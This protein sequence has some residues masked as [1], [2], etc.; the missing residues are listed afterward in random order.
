MTDHSHPDHSHPDRAETVREFRNVANMTPAALRK[1]LEGSDSKSVGMT[2][3]GERVTEE[4]GDESVGHEMGRRILELKAKKA[5]DI[6]EDDLLAMRKVIG[7]V[8]R[9]G[10][11][12]PHGDVT[13]TRWRKSLMNWGHD[14]LKD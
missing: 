6:T 2:H 11:Q 4:G 10:K 13:D 14:P 5:A 8:H 12:R 7:Y 1:W 3:E 9:H